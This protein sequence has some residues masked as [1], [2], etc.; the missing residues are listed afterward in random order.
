MRT[1][2]QDSLI[3]VLTPCFIT[4]CFRTLCFRILCFKT[5]YSTTVFVY[6]GGTKLHF[7]ELVIAL[8]V[9]L[10]CVRSSVYMTILKQRMGGGTQ[11]TDQ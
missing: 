4:L 8:S 9:V 2:F 11:F 6:V 7:T 1:T 5:L 3:L 10:N